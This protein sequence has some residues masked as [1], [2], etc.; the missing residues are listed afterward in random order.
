MEKKKIVGVL[1]AVKARRLSV[2]Q[3]FEKLKHLPYEDLGFAKVDHHRRI[4]SGMP[5]VVFCQGKT[6]PQIVEIFCSLRKK[7]KAVLLTRADA[8]IFTELKKIEPRLVFHAPAGVLY[9]PA[10][11]C[12]RR[13]KIAVVCAGTADI[14]VAEEAA[15]TAE[16][17]GN[18]V[19]RVYDVGVAGLHRLFAQRK[20]IQ[21]SRCVIVL[22]GMEGALAS[23]M[24]GLVDCPV[25]AVP[26]SIG[27]GA[28]FKG[29]TPLLTMI[30]SCS[31]NIS[32]VNIN[33]GFGA[34][35]IAS[36]IN[37]R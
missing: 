22:A 21:G 13:G 35:Y 11:T 32:V 14:P 7:N 16:V 1:A 2:A 23:V 31:P 37:R 28:S 34:G 12:S 33:N 10:K 3:A 25:I 17:F 36:L 15:L 26:T 9:L 29:V 20:K 19:E 24:G 18:R 30:N 27:Y 5:E 8:K 6:L 4:R